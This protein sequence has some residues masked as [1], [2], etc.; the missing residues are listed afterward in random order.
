MSN[1]LGM[2]ENYSNN[3]HAQSICHFFAKDLL[4]K[5]AEECVPTKNIINIAVYGC[6]PGD[7]DL[8]AI[9]KYI[10]PILYRRFP[11]NT[12]KIFMIDIKNTK[13]CEIKKINNI[14]IQGI[15]ADLYTKILTN[16]SVDIGL[17]FSCI[18]WIDKLP[19][20]INNKKYCWSLLNHED[21]DII[22]DILK[23]RLN[24]FMLARNEE[25]TKNGQLILTCDGYSKNS[26]H[27]FQKLSELISIYLNN[28]F[29]NLPD[30][31]LNKFFLFTGPRKI[32]DIEYCINNINNLNY[33]KGEIFI[34][35]AECPYLDK[36][37]NKTNRINDVTE[38][39]N[40]K[41]QY[42][43]DIT[44]S[45]M[46][47]ITPQIEYLLDNDYIFEIID[48]IRKN[49]LSLVINSHIDRFTTKGDVLVFR[50]YK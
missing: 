10:I 48:N 25:L 11:Q 45:I 21:K 49:L 43:T 29:N 7:N 46:S 15:T 41:K 23:T 44:D 22:A 9:R 2:S 6:G 40:A 32:S 27:H 4:I 18:H 1:Y 20:N 34:K 38:L 36:Y 12:I 5:A 8:D 42:A 28:K 47:C 31:L 37:I 39:K 14:L 35:T 26:L 17:S 13:W 24:K 30:K 19:K 33:N 3:S 50:C 16:N